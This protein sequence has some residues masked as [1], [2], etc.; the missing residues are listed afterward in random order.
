VMAVVTPAERP[1]A[2][3]L[4]LVPR[5]LASAAGPLLAGYLLGLGAFGDALILA[6]G[7]KVVYDLTL[8]G[9]FRRHP[10]PEEQG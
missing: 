9:L 8:F 3:S 5:S 7:L 2:A 4:T 1:A 6:G 10:P